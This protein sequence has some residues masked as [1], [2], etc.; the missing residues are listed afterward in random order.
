MSQ[1]FPR[2]RNRE[3]RAKDLNNSTKRCMDNNE[4]KRCLAPLVPGEMQIKARKI[5]TQPPEQLELR[6]I[7]SERM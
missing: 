2:H 1:E 7:M 5:H 6:P 3:K 4:M